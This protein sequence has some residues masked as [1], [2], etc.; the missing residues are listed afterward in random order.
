MTG[1]ERVRRALNHQPA[2]RV[3][4]DLGAT[5]TTGIAASA[6]ATLRKALG[7]ARPGERVKVVEPFQMLGEVDEELRRAIGVDCVWL[8]G[9][10][11][12]FGFENA[13]WK[14]WTLFDGTAVLV[15]GGFNTQPAPD[16]SILMYPR[17]DRTAAPSGK[18]P[19]GGF[20]FDAL[21]RQRPVVDA[22]LRVEDN[23]AEFG[24]LCDADLAHLQREADRLRRETDLA[25]V[26]GGPG[27]A[28]GDIALVPA[29]WL[30]DPPGVRG[31]AEWY[32]SL[33]TRRP[34][35]RELFDRQCR[36]ALD[37]L[38]LMRQAVGDRIDVIF[39]TGTDFGGQRGLLVSPD[40]YRE[41][42]KPFNRRLNDWVHQHTGWKTFVHSCGAVEPLIG[43]FIDAGFDVLNPVQCSADGM[44]PRRL[45]QTYGGR[46]VFWGG[47]VDTQRTLPFGTP[48][49]VAEEVAERLRIF[50]AGGGYVFN[51]VHNVQAN[52][53]AENLLAMVRQISQQSL[54][55]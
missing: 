30:K 45:K 50:G 14:P 25:I 26:A 13:A 2:D 33:A 18:M 20:Y 39:M 38:E 48:R 44:D 36:I 5:P 34:F 7:L 32:M 46:I 16:G 9:R 35:L 24:R 55:S 15:P 8:A 37:N 53:P 21:D 42:F 31:V 52:T 49:Q 27:T 40:L 22:T 54:T 23:L 10:T 19:A 3:P 43:E 28:F 4:V 6:V 11:N 1:R 51:P 12:M 17:G 47:G 41:L 29:P